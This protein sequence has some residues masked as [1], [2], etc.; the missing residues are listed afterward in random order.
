V[1]IGLD[2]F[3]D[4][5]NTSSMLRVVLLLALSAPLVRA[6]LITMHHLAENEKCME[7]TFD[8]AD[9]S[10]VQSYAAPMIAQASGNM[11]HEGTCSQNGFT[12]DLGGREMLRIPFVKDAVIRTSWKMSTWNT[13]KLKAEGF[14]ASPLSFFRGSA[15][16]P[17]SQLVNAPK[18][19]ALASTGATDA[20]KAHAEW[21]GPMGD[22]ADLCVAVD[23]AGQ[24]KDV[25]EEIEYQK[26]RT[27]AQAAGKPI[28]GP[29][30]DWL[31]LCSVAPDDL[32]RSD[33]QD[34][35]EYLDM[36]AD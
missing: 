13:M 17:S 19:P 11:I 21:F 26:K 30:G 7:Y 6:E 20:E 27:H 32:A 29:T 1:P 9:K 10:Y 8:R 18:V 24:F 22:F 23:D 15:P 14:L 5:F 3:A 34:M 36:E 4:R 2:L 16:H 35:C 33:A 12:E 31:E 25:C 28:T